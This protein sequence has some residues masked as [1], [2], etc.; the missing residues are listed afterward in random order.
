MSAFQ[1]HEPATSTAPPFF[2]RRSTDGFLKA[3]LDILIDVVTE[4]KTKGNEM[5]EIV[6]SLDKQSALTTQSIDALVVRLDRLNGSVARHEQQLTENALLRAK[7]QGRNEGFGK[8]AIA[9]QPIVYGGLLALAIILLQNAPSILH[10]I[11]K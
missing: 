10:A 11:G 7:E 6:A 3:Q 1:Q 9:L 2:N 4:V 5:A 8:V